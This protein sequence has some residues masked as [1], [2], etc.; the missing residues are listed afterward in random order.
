MD[1]F[2]V[3]FKLLHPQEYSSGDTHL[4]IDIHYH[5]LNRLPAAPI[6]SQINPV[7]T[8]PCYLFKS[9]LYYSHIY[10]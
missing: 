1:D 9:I 2:T 10:I 5:F 4:N 8:L 6:P 7:Y 3:L